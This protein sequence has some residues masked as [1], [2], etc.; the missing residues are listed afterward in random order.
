MT[1][2]TE[3]EAAALPPLP[4]P[5]RWHAVLAEHQ[6]PHQTKTGLHDVGFRD[7]R[8]AENFAASEKDFNGWEYSV[9]PLYSA[10][11]MR[12]AIAAHAAGA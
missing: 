7:Y 4:E 8:T 2:R 9:H 3:F 11:Q 5:V 10:D 12:A 6:R 1:T